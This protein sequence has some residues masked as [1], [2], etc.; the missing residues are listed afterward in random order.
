MD[1]N[2]IVETNLAPSSSVPR[3]FL[4][5]KD[6]MFPVSIW[7]RDKVRNVAVGSLL[8]ALFVYWILSN[9]LQNNPDDLKIDMIE[10]EID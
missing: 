2:L 10:K 4:W 5:L 9:V 6:H 1:D 8:S 7:G 3:M